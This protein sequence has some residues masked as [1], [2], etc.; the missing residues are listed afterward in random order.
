[1]ATGRQYNSDPRIIAG[2]FIGSV[3]NLKR[4]PTKSRSDMGTE[5]G[6]EE[7]MQKLMRADGN[8]SFI[9]GKSV[10]NQR[11]ESWWGILRK[12]SAQ[13]WKNIFSYLKDN[14][15]LSGNVLDNNFARF[16]FLKLI[17]VG[18]DHMYLI[19]QLVSTKRH[20]LIYPNAFPCRYQFHN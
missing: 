17:Q 8:R 19:K 16:C 1:M 6:L 3:E 15:H 5:N 11:I 4:C 14:D 9:Q 20:S 18:Y 10:A 13:Y 7:V 12:E 2:Y